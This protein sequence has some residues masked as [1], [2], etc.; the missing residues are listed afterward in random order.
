MKLEILD[1]GGP[2]DSQILERGSRAR[3]RSRARSGRVRQGLPAEPEGAGL[4]PAAVLGGAE[5][6]AA[7]AGRDA[8][9]DV[10][11]ALRPDRRRARTTSAKTRAATARCRTAPSRRWTRRGRRRARTPFDSRRPA[12]ATCSRSRSRLDPRVKTAGRR[13]RAAHHALEGDVRQCGGRAGGV[14]V[15]RARCS[16]RLGSCRGCSGAARNSIP[17]AP[18]KQPDA[19]ERRGRGR[20]ESE[21]PSTFDERGQRAHG[22]CHGNAGRRHGAHGGADRRVRAG[23][24]QLSCGAGAMEARRRRCATS[25][26]GSYVR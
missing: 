5:R 24:R 18:A 6:G 9:R 7:D 1:N 21:A 11:S 3:S 15:R 14:R 23:A 16:A 4:Q 8:P 17:L 19:D 25:G 26:C 20:R 12:R 13:A 10:G 22:R 2:R